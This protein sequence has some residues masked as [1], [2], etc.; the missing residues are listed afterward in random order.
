FPAFGEKNMQPYINAAVAPKPDA[1]V[2]GEF[3]TDILTLWKQWIASGI[4]IPNLTLSGSPNLEAVKSASEMPPKS[5]GF[6]RGD[7][8]VLRKTP[9]GAEV[10]KLYIAKYGH[11]QHPLPSAWAFAWVS[12]AQMAKAL[13]EATKSLSPDAWVKVVESGKFTFKSPYHTGP[14]SVDP[15][16]HMADT[17]VTVGHL[18]FKKGSPVPAQYDPKN[19]IQVC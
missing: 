10:S 3:S 8:S 15:V 14:T 18:I 17:C 13:I 1:V 5:F 16:N 19:T 12:G 7:W 2:G 6:L 9:I 11:S 4:K